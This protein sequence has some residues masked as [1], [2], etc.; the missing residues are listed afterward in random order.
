M[1]AIRIGLVV[2]AAAMITFGLGGTA[3]A[4]HSGGVA[5]CD[6]CHTMHG[7]QDGAVMNRG[8]TSAAITVG[9]VTTPSL[10]MGSDPSSVCL[11]CHIGN[12][13]YHIASADNTLVNYNA[14]GDFTW[15]T[16]T[17]SYLVRGNPV[18]GGGEGVGHNI[19]SGDYGYQADATLS[20]APGGTF[21]AG[22]LY[23][24][25]CH[26]PHGRVRSQLGTPVSAP[27]SGS[28]SYGDPVPTDGSILGNYRLL[29]DSQ[30]TPSIGSN[31]VYTGFDADAPIATASNT[32]FYGSSVDYGSGMSN[33][34]KN[35]H[36]KTPGVMHHVDE[37]ANLVSSG[38]AENY[39]KYVATGDLTGDPTGA[40][41]SGSYDGLVPIER[42]VTIGAD[43]DPS[44]TAGA[45]G[46]SHVMCLTCHR[47]H[48][49]AYD[50]IGRW[51]FGAELLTETGLLDPS[52]TTSL[53]DHNAGTYKNGASVDIA[54]AYSPYQR[55]LC[56]KCHV[57]D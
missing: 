15:L 5:H 47:A 44:S 21:P 40:E 53:A 24:T 16:N 36:W 22:Q 4:F 38:Y 56:N 11:N 35:C 41:G 12:G 55:S 23:C 26:D 3:L 10:L 2:M 8:N 31:S 48:A 18:T 46:N 57:N 37:N 51:D 29:G 49:S 20:V 43:L 17:Y 34:C 32:G 28:G 42:G 52:V 45:S 14:G 33:W 25:S 30:Y 13:S 54:T 6:G 50:N 39:N 9:N 27:I 19:I 1:K 7:S